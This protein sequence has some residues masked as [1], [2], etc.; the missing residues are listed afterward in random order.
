MDEDTP[1]PTVE[2]LDGF[3]AEYE[4]IKELVDDEASVTPFIR[5]GDYRITIQYPT[6][7][8]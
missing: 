1:S 3:I 8:D 6:E 7:N 5:P 2:E 4:A